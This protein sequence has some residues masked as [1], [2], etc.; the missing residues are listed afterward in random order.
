MNNPSLGW[1]RK[2]ASRRWLVLA[3]MALVVTL[4]LVL[5]LAR[6]NKD[7]L[8]IALALSGLPI[9]VLM[10]CLNA[11]VRGL[12]ELCDRDLDER[13]RSL[14]DPA[15]R[16]LYTPAVTAGFIVTLV[17]ILADLSLGERLALAYTSYLLVLGA[18]VAWLAWSLPDEMHDLG[19]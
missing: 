10:G 19:D 13:E 12:T 1:T 2:R 16:R 8:A 17:A 6:E 14:R 3:Y 15:Y 11:G 4:G 18:P 7:I 5:G 9:V